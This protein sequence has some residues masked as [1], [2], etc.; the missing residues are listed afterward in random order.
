MNTGIAGM[1][2]KNEKSDNV[3]FSNNYI[4]ER[5]MLSWSYCAYCGKSF[6]SVVTNKNKHKIECHDDDDQQQQQQQQRRC[7]FLICYDKTTETKFIR[8]ACET[9]L[10]MNSGFSHGDVHGNICIYNKKSN[11]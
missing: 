6:S 5:A 7:P 9:C 11:S 10:W 3:D 1:I 4:G 8:A 2:E